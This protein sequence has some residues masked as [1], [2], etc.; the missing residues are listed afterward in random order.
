MRSDDYDIA[1]VTLT[2]AM[3]WLRGE[4]WAKF[5]DDLD[6]SRCEIAF[7]N[8]LGN[9]ASWRSAILA[10]RGLMERGARAAIAHPTSPIMLRH[11]LKAG[12][13]VTMEERVFWRS[14]ELTAWRVFV[15]PQGW[16]AWNEKVK[17]L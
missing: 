15:P 4:R 9:R 6:T 14:A 2:S 13:I 11:Y 10:A 5:A 3:E 1:G 16:M 7:L 12:G 8:E 17:D